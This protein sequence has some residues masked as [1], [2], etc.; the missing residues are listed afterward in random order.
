MARL[1]DDHPFLVETTR[2]MYRSGDGVEQ[3]GVDRGRA[4]EWVE[5]LL[6]LTIGGAQA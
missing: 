3:Y 6:G 4:E 1:Y 2:Q 5:T